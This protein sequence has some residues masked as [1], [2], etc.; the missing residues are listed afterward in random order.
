M[1]EI[2]Y[3]TLQDELFNLEEPNLSVENW[4]GLTKWKSNKIE[5]VG[6]SP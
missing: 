3:F 1:T 5:L 4:H 2:I 6:G